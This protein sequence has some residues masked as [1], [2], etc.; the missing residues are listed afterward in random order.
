MEQQK[1]CSILLFIANSYR[2]LTVLNKYYNKLNKIF[3]VILVINLF[4]IVNNFALSQMVRNQGA[5][6]DVRPNQSDIYSENHNIDFKILK[7]A[8][9]GKSIHN[10]TYIIVADNNEAIIV[11]PYGDYNIVFNAKQLVDPNTGKCVRI[12]S[13]DDLNKEYVVSGDW[14]TDKKSGERFIIYVYYTTSSPYNSVEN[15]ETIKEIIDENK[16]DI[17]YIFITH[18]HLDHFGDLNEVKEMTNAEVVMHIA[19][20]RL[21]DGSRLTDD[22][23]D[24]VISKQLSVYPKDTY[25][26]QELKTEVNKLVTHGDT[27]TIGNLSFTVQHLPG[28][29]MGSIG[30]YIETGGNPVLFSGDAFFNNGLTKLKYVD[31][32]GDKDEYENTMRYIKTL[33]SNTAV[34]SATG[35]PFNIEKTVG[36]PKD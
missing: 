30:L 28:H 2:M 3:K 17:R 16:L 34:L 24:A 31:G 36:Y 26:F 32:S 22:D 6:G 4:F 14:A 1:C 5:I 7:K 12:I 21:I 9:S 15:F 33:P 20:V 35:T 27:L 18:G 13:I 8:S 19:D 23:I 10:S 25:R 11:D 29:S